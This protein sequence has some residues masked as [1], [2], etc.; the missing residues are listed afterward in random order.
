VDG[1]EAEMH[2]ILLVDDEPEIL[3][4]WRLVLINEG[5]DVRCAHNGVEALDTVKL[6]IPNLVIT[7]WKM[8]LM[9]GAEFCRRLKALPDLARIPILIHSA[10]LP[11]PDRLQASNAYLRKPVN[12]PLF[13]RTVARLCK[14]CGRPSNGTGKA[15]SSSSG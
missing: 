14:Q 15:S 13:L 5:Y 7:D 12:V 10:A 1:Q 9:D 2:S 8:P 4:A 3:A 11:S 6:G